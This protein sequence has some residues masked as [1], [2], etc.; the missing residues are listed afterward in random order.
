VH[1]RV[2]PGAPAIKMEMV[3]K[4]NHSSAQE[5]AVLHVAGNDWFALR[6]MSLW[7]LHTPPCGDPLAHF[8]SSATAAK[9]P[10]V[11]L[12]PQPQ[13]STAFDEVD[14]RPWHVLVPAEIRGHA[15]RMA[16]AEQRG[17]SSGVDQ[18]IHVYF[19]THRA[20]LS[21]VGCERMIV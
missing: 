18:V 21:V 15:I 14:N 10:R 9:L 4:R 5:L 17:H 6:A 16:Q 20:L 2:A 12:R 3:T 1:V 11:N 19:P 13:T 8:E 7:L